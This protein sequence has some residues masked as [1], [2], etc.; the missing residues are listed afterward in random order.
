MRDPRKPYPT[1]YLLKYTILP[2]IPQWVTPNQVTVLRIV[3]T[4]LAIWL[5]VVENYRVAIPFFLFV[6]LTDA[7]D[8]AMARMRNQITEWG[9]MWDPI[10]DKL[11]IGLAVFVIVLEHVN[12]FL[13]LLLLLVELIAVIGG[14]W[15]FRGGKVYPANVWGKI[16]MVLE[17]LGVTTL[18]VAL[19]FQINLLVQ[20][21]FG[22][23]ALALVFAVMSLVTHTR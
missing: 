5:I 22:T 9:T 16:K 17:V 11:F 6:A 14:Y 19:A 8:G 21:S 13:G 7:I 20:L 3:L 15:R 2:L 12:I 4:P 1:D 23:L 18:L 10:A